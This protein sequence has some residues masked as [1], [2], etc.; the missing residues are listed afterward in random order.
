METSGSDHSFLRIIE[1]EDADL[2]W[3][4]DLGETDPIKATPVVVDIDD[5]G[6]PEVVVV[7]DSEGSMYVEAWS[8]RLSC[9]VTGW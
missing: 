5:D 3:Q 4:V 6:M 8:P 1:G 2:A 9:S 7:Y